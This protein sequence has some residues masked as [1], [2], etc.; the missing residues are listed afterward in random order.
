MI[1]LSQAARSN[2]VV[3]A[4]DATPIIVLFFFLKKKKIIK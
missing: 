1:S 2:H 3:Q 4:V